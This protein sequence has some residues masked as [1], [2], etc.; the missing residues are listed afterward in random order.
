MQKAYLLLGGNIGNKSENLL[1]AELLISSKIGKIM[2]RSSIY[3]SEAW[4]FESKNT[5]YNKAI[6][7]ETKLDSYKLLD[8]IQKIEEELG[9]VRGEIQWTD[10]IIDIDIL[11][12]ENNVIN[13]ERLTIPHKLLPK[14]KFALEPLAEI[15]GKIFHPILKKTIS[16]LLE[17]C[18]E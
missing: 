13:T 3:E 16:R 10:R 2:R 17:D 1:N 18:V 4:G 6:I 7:V 8:E 9:R 15:A 12:Y 14:R 11:L 5:F